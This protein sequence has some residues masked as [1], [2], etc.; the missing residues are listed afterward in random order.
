MAREAKKSGGVRWRLWLGLAVAASLCVSTGMAAWKV[1]RYALTGAQFTLSASR[2]DALEIQGLT[3]G[4]RAKVRRVFAADFGG[5]VFAIPLAERRRRL[6]AIDWVEDASVSRIWPDR[7]LVRIRERRPVAFVP[8]RTGAVLIDADGVLLEPP[9][10]AQFA[11]PVLIGVREDEPE[12]ARRER[13]TA[14][15]RFQKDMGYLAKDVSEV[16]V[17]NPDD[18]RIVARVDNRALGLLMGGGDFARHYQ[19]FLNHYAETQKGSPE[20]GTFD[21]RWDGHIVAK[22]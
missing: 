11:F 9:A 8:L 21:L 16:D 19:N 20:A 22:R 4:S 14:F 1:R 7:L 12:A 17:A 10:R 18:L 5:S 6:L 2:Q 15:L 3:D 13:V